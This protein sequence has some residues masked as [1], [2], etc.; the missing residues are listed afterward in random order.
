VRTGLC[1]SLVLLA[2]TIA[3]GLYSG[4]EVRM[5]S[6][7]YVS[8]A[9]EL[10]ILTEK[11]EWAR[12]ADIAAAYLKTWRDTVPVLQTLINH[13]D[14]DSVTLS[15]LQLQ[16]AIR[17]RDNSGCFTACAELRENALHLYHRDGFTLAN[18]L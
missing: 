15:L 3:G 10:S 14:T 18:V 13:E 8:A 12:A 9:E 7:R 1:V 6:E 17:A 2:L 4:R 11:Q 5:I 16:A